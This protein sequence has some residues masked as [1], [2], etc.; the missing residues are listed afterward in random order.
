MRLTQ[1]FRF[2]NNIARIAN[3][4]LH[5]FKKEENK[6]VGTPVHTLAKPKWNHKKYTV[7]A[8]TNAGVFDQ[9]AK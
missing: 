9:A 5:T 8:R 3:M 1:S 4:V 7:I 2:D 6:I